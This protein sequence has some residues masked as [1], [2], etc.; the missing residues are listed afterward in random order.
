MVWAEH[1]KILT[2]RPFQRRSAKQYRKLPERLKQRK[3]RRRSESRREDEKTDHDG[4]WR[5]PLN[6]S[7]IQRLVDFIMTPKYNLAKPRNFAD[8]GRA[9]EIA[10]QNVGRY[11]RDFPD[12]PV[13]EQDKIYD[14]AK[15]NAFLEDH[16]L[17]P[18]HWHGKMTR[19]ENDLE[20]RWLAAKY[21][22]VLT[23][24]GG[25]RY[26]TRMLLKEEAK[27][28][29]RELLWRM[30][31]QKRGHGHPPKRNY[32]LDMSDELA[33]VIEE[34]LRWK[35]RS[36][37]LFPSPLD[38]DLMLPHPEWRPASCSFFARYLEEA[39]E[40]TGLENEIGHS[41]WFHDFRHFF[42]VRAV[43]SLVFPWQVAR[44]CCHCDDKMIR[45]VYCLNLHIDVRK[46][47]AD[48][49]HFA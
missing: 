37:W 24:S 39:V 23:Y 28:P 16:D 33:S 21:I 19:I 26:A 6:L 48:K 40:A 47:F 25:R 14:L 20:N 34:L 29:K 9:L 35:P 30:E 42:I 5:E 1:K 31:T 17:H 43:S 2:A 7:Q 32:I 49:V 3:L 12:F 38:P 18:G 10:P 44:W 41:V 45:D 22:Q 15:V 11:A 36:P 27:L 46:M 13:P 8:I 4:E